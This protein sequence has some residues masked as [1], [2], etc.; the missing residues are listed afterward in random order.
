MIGAGAASAGVPFPLADDESLVAEFRRRGWSA[1]EGRASALYAGVVL[2]GVVSTL[3][4]LELAVNLGAWRMILPPLVPL[5]FLLALLEAGRW[6]SWRSGVWYVTSAR[7]VGVRGVMFRRHAERSLSAGMLVEAGAGL[8]YQLT[9]PDQPALSLAGLEH[10]EAEGLAHAAHAKL[11]AT[12]DVAHAGRRRA[13][14]RAVLLGIGLASASIGAEGLRRVEA[15][16][17]LAFRNRVAATQLA[18]V[19]AVRMTKSE[20][21]R[22]ATQRAAMSPAAERAARLRLAQEVD[23]AAGGGESLFDFGYIDLADSV[24][25]RDLRLAMAEVDGEVLREETRVHVVVECLRPWRL[26]PAG[27]DPVR[28]TPVGGTERALFVEALVSELEGAGIPFV[29]D[30]DR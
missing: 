14:R 16:R 27:P 30:P 13:N 24:W 6:A 19:A 28:I 12:P 8:G 25:R 22:L 4:G 11:V 10:E 7:V 3:A 20:L 26:L 2:A 29:L 1:P 18:T 9:A 17:R 5:G 21:R 23:E 15:A